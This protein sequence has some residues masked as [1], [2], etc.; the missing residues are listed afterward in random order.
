MK[1]AL[2]GGGS[3]GHF[4]PLI[5]VAERINEQVKERRLLPPQMYYIGP[6]PFDQNSL[7][8][9]DIT[10]KK[11]LAGKIRRE[12][13]SVIRNF[14]DYFKTLNSAISPPFFNDLA[15]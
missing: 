13:G 11:G 15:A 4:Y 7:I 5:A 9:Q 12:K 8:E 3:G 2:V 1:I 10:Y 6:K 14:F